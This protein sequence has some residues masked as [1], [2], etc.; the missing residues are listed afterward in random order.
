MLA[1]IIALLCV[2]VYLT[3]MAFTYWACVRSEIH[4]RKKEGDPIR[5][6][7]KD[8]LRFPA[9]TMGFFWPVILLLLPL[10]IF[11]PVIKELDKM[12]FSGT[13]DD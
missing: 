2:T 9:A 1:L 7:N 12:A 10:L 8:D 3:G 4:T 13:D 11:I 5:S 6:W